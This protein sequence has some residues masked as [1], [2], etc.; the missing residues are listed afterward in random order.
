MKK[1]LKLLVLILVLLSTDLISSQII[2][3]DFGNNNAKLNWTAV[4][5]SY[6]L[7]NNPTDGSQKVGA[8]TKSTNHPYSLFKADVPNG[9]DLSESNQF[10]I[11]IYSG[12]KHPFILKLNGPSGA[13]EK[14]VHIEKINTW[15]TYTID[16]SQWA[17]LQGLNSIELFFDPSSNRGE[18]YYFDDIISYTSEELRT[19]KEVHPNDRQ[20]ELIDNFELSFKPW[21][22]NGGTLTKVSNPNITIPNTSANCG[23]FSKTQGQPYTWISYDISSI[24]FKGN[25]ELNLKVFLKD[26]PHTPSEHNA[27]LIVKLE[28]A[29]SGIT[30]IERR[31]EIRG[32]NQW[33]SYAFD[34][35]NVNLND[36]THLNIFFGAGD[37]TYG[38]SYYFDDVLVAPTRTYE[39]D[40]TRTLNQLREAAYE[41]FKLSRAENGM[42]LDKKN[43]LNNHDA[44][45]GSTAAVGM[46]LIALCIG[47]DNGWEP[48]AVTKVIKTLQTVAGYTPGFKLSRNTTGF[49]SHFFDMH[50]GEKARGSEYSVIDTAILMSGALFAKE[51]FSELEHGAPVIATPEQRD[52]IAKLILDL[53]NTTKWEDVISNHSLSELFLEFDAEGKGKGGSQAFSEYMIAA[54]MANRTGDSTGTLFWNTYYKN[55]TNLRKAPF[56]YIAPNGTTTITQTLAFDLKHIHSSFLT[57]FANYLVYGF[58]NNPDLNPYLKNAKIADKNWWKSISESGYSNPIPRQLYEWGCGAGESNTGYGYHADKVDS[59]GEEQNWSKIVSPHIIAGFLPADENKE[60]ENDLLNLYKSGRGLYK[61][62]NAKKSE[63]LWRYSK[64]EINWRPEVIQLVDFSTMLFG[65]QHLKDLTFFK[66][67]TNFSNMSYSFSSLVCEKYLPWDKNYTYVENNLVNYTKANGSSEVYISLGKSTNKDPENNLSLWKSVGSCSSELKLNCIDYKEHGTEGSTGD[68][69]RDYIVKVKKETSPGSGIWDWE[70]YQAK[71]IISKS[72]TDSYNV[73]NKN[74]QNAWRFLGNCKLTTTT[75]TTTTAATQKATAS[76][77]LTTNTVDTINP[78]VIISPNPVDNYL[79]VTVKGNYAISNIS[80]YDLNGRVLLTSKSSKVNVSSLS[81]GMYILKL[82]TS[83]GKETSSKFIKK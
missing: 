6:N 8:Y 32:Y 80:V 76:K 62:P 5:G 75:T 58:N 7:E 12:H 82:Q 45:A 71:W 56:T 10:R 69:P 64:E 65:L 26:R 9:I 57:Q 25:N 78:D 1:Q 81:N 41:V 34:F 20:G 29:P 31:T 36:F 54:D 11:R 33:H 73:P 28:G 24:D 53:W 4:D 15:Q 19:I 3:E 61:L 77:T 17:S 68:Y 47:H 59:Q 42:Y 74:A 43:I 35:S 48:D 39:E 72:A 70:L 51:Y 37:G 13:I 38:G 30:Q 49:A 52:E 50:T 79:S 18:K 67:Y 63:V 55:S 66:K 16:F 14:T 46:G 44:H 23:K 21:T 83:D 2:Y 40:N 27:K 60:I 22:A